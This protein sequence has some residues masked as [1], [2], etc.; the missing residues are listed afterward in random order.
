[1]NRP[2]TRV[3]AGRGFR[4]RLADGSWLGKRTELARIRALAIPPAWTDVSISDRPRARIQATGY[5]A[6]GRK[7]YIYDPAYRRSQDARKFRALREFGE[8]L[9]RLRRQVSRDLRR[10]G[11]PRE[12]V[13]A[14]VVA[15]LEAT[16]MRIGNEQYASANHSYGLTTLRSQQVSVADGTV[17]FVFN[18]KSG[19]RH[20]IVLEDRKLARL[21]ARCRAAPGQE[22][23]QYARDDGSWV[24]VRSDDVNGYLR[25]VTG[26]DITAKAFR[27]WSASVLA[28]SLLAS[29]TKMAPAERKSIVRQAVETVAAALGNTP[30]V[31]RDSYIHPHVLSC[32]LA[33]DLDVSPTRRGV[34]WLSADERRLLALLEGATA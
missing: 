10:R 33:D 28:L 12:K 30:T 14:T 18:G 23:F 2:I 32:Y 1:M 21:V 25:D 3:R 31:C 7:Q 26:S 29:E 34:G 8:V 11:L 16:R 15:L 4:Y 24:P 9:P 6:R 20:R 22:L 27:T 19:R 13:L 17:R 5:D